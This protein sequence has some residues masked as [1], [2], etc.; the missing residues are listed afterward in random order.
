M[1]PDLCV[2]EDRLLAVGSQPAALPQDLCSPPGD[3]FL[4][5]MPGPPT[6]VSLFHEKRETQI[7][8]DTEQSVL[9][10]LLAAKPSVSHGVPALT[11]LPP[12]LAFISRIRAPLEG[13]ETGMRQGQCGYLPSSP[14]P[15]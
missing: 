13:P 1:R 14:G 8:A 10:R 5:G 11:G 7:P 3:P 12:L 6:D 15:R 4:Q 2:V 9:P